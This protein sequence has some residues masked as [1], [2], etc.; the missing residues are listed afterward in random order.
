MGDVQ[1][2]EEEEKALELIFLSSNFTKLFIPVISP[3]VVGQ[4]YPG[5]CCNCYGFPTRYD[6]KKLVVNIA[7][8]LVTGH[9]K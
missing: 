5:D 1:R 4:G 7:C 9:G 8:T 3:D 2:K 6:G